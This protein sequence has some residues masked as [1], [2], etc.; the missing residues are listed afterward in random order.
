MFVL[1][2]RLEADTHAIVD[3]PVSSVRLMN[4]ATYPWLILVPRQNEIRELYE[5]SQADRNQ[6][7]EE[8]SQAS[9]VLNGLYGLDKINVGAIG[10]MVPQLHIHVIART[11]SDPSWPGPVWGA[12]PPKPYDDETFSATLRT[13]SKALEGVFS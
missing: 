2:E 12:H 6:V 10:N 5:L 7:M 13:L 8:I 9:K 4:D 1:H 3:W 11:V